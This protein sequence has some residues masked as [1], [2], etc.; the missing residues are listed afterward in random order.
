MTKDLRKHQLELLQRARELVLGTV[1]ETVTTSDVTPGGGKSLGVSLFT[2]A[3]ADAKFITHVMWAT[4]RISLAE[5]AALGFRDDELNPRYSVRIADNKPPLFRDV[6]V[7][8][9]GYTTTYQA[10]SKAPDLHQAAFDLPG[11]SILLVLDELHHLVHNDDGGDPDKA[12][13]RAW[14]EALAPLVAKAKHVLVLSGTLER[15]DREPIPFIGYEENEAGLRV[16]VRHI[17]YTRRE[18]LA[19]K[20]ILPI[21]IRF[22]DGIATYRHLGADVTQDIGT[23]DEAEVSRVIRTFLADPEFREAVLRDG[24]SHWTSFRETRYAS[25]AIVVCADQEMAREAQAYIRSQFNVGVVLAISDEPRSREVLRRFR[26]DKLGDVLVTVGMAYEGLDVPDCT[27]LICLT[28]IR[29][30]PWLEQA[31]ARIS[32]I[33]WKAMEKGFGY[34]EQR[35]F[36]FA[37]R[38]PK[39]QAI[40]DAIMQEQ[41]LGLA[42]ARQREDE[43][44]GG[45]T[46]G[47]DPEGPDPDPDDDLVDDGF[48]PISAEITG[49][50]YGSMEEGQLSAEESA[51]VERLL[52]ECPEFKS[53]PARRLLQ[54][55]ASLRGEGL[56]TSFLEGARRYVEG[57]PQVAPARPYD[58]LDEER[59]RKTIE[60]RARRLDRRRGWEYG[61]TNQRVVARYGRR[62][63]EM[64]VQEL[65]QVL[66]YIERLER[67]RS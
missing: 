41:E 48:H 34:D 56:M 6:N 46:D 14:T 30:R 50:R 19:E 33:D 54:M 11:H 44:H 36:V 5:Q 7:G 20:A 28:H 27:H 25:R 32:R 49:T 26:D 59:L 60:E 63:E 37:P 16:P 61:S 55:A 38:D 43:A 39:M 10:I 47:G 18:A 24:L 40:V 23:A 22:A 53:L 3:L 57:G 67:Q 8:C 66:S 2:R 64:G 29:S 13:Q 35:G 1:T 45:N 62:R 42:D 4:P 52:S 31:F 51:Q 9:I 15:W 58:P 17:R 21:E 65:R 12:Q